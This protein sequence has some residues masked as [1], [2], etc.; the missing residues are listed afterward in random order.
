MFKCPKKYTFSNL[1]IK[2]RETKK[3]SETSSMFE[4]EMQMRG[5]LELFKNR[6]SISSGSPYFAQ[7]GFHDKYSI[8][9]FLLLQ[10]DTP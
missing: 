9:I 2:S 4:V 1:R 7:G 5:F 10:R 6:H 3:S 8:G